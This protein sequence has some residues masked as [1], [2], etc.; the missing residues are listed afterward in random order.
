MDLL[1]LKYFD[2]EVLYYKYDC[3]ESIHVAHDSAEDTKILSHYIH[4]T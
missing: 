3:N 1:Y 4:K 2:L